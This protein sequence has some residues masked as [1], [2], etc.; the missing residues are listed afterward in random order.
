MLQKEISFG[1]GFGEL[2]GSSIRIEAKLDILLASQAT[3]LS[4]AHGTKEEDELQEMN[5][6]IN[7]MI[8]A[9]VAR[10]GFASK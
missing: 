8:D 10:R 1:E 4:K 3:L 7:K 5:K 2:I 9:E 6:A